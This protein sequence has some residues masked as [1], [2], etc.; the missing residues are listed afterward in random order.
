MP[1]M[2]MKAPN[3][4]PSFRPPPQSGVTQIGGR[5]ERRGGGRKKN[6]SSVGIPHTDFA[7]LKGRGM[8]RPSD[9]EEKSLAFALVV[10]QRS[11]FSSSVFP[12]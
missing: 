6:P 2:M 9:K 8:E 7:A 1:L 4:P 3:L 11:E 5:R 10:E 12:C